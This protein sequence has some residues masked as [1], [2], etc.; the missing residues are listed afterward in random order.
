ML[1]AGV[2]ESLKGILHD[3]T[4]DVRVQYMI[5][6]MFAVRKDGFKEHPAIT[7]GL[8]L[9]DE[10]DQIT[11]LL[12]LEDDLDE[13][14]TLRKLLDVMYNCYSMYYVHV[15]ATM[16]NTYYINQYLHKIVY[17]IIL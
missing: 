14:Q 9:V 15:N 8:G 6:V 1:L 3:G 13:E 16:L 2:F 7:E 5:E 17:Y 11:H 10:D 12:S 4:I